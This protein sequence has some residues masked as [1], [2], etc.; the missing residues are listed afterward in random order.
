MLSNK[1]VNHL[2]NKN[3]WFDDVTDEYKNALAQL[4]VD[5]SS[6]FAQF[7][8]HAE[9]GPTFISK[10]REIYQICWFLIN[11]SDYK[12]S[13]KRT[14]ETLKLPQEYLPLDN[15][16]G[17]YGFFYN[18]NT[19]EVLRLGLGDEWHSFFAGTLKPQW[20]DFNAFLEW[21]FDLDN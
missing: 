2:K 20:P 15:F 19:G 13:M 8:L 4:G 6:D 21:Y 7:Y 10:N 17:D 5:M 11:S 16:Q 12:W 3:W 14:Q 18:K 1:L 9:D